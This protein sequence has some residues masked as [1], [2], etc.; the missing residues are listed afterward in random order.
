MPGPLLIPLIAAGA[1]LAGQGINAMAQGKMNRKTRQWNEKMYA[2]QRADSLSDYTMQ[3]E[4]NSPASQMQ[5]LR[6]AGLNPNLVY[7]NGAT[8]TGGTVRSSAAPAWN[9]KAPQIESSGIGNSL[10]SYY[11]IQLREAQ[12]DN[13]RTQNTV[14]AE[15]KALKAAQT[16]ATLMGATKTGIDSESQKFDLSQRVRLADTAAEAAKA[17]LDKIKADTTFTTDSNTRANQRQPYD[18]A[19]VVENILTQEAGRKLTSAQ[20]D[21][22]NAQIK[23]MGLDSKLK[24]L[25]IDMRKDGIMPSDPLYMRAIQKLINGSGLQNKIKEFAPLNQYTPKQPWEF[26]K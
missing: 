15:E 4:Y 7:G 12:T 16:Y 8:A 26:W 25:D 17:S 13:L 21:S 2:Q 14:L 3:N 11:D 18:L 6:D 10:M 1:S 19:M 9:P 5:R 20:I 24:Q 23:N 22:I